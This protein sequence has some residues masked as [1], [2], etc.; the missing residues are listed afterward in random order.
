MQL[1]VSY[2]FKR[3]ALKNDF[4]IRQY[5]IE[6]GM[7]LLKDDEG[8]N[9]LETSLE[10]HQI[11]NVIRTS[12]HRS[13]IAPPHISVSE[14]RRN[15]TISSVS[16]VSAMI[17]NGCDGNNTNGNGTNGESNSNVNGF[18]HPSSRPLNVRPIQIKTEPID[19][20][21]EDTT[22][23]QQSKNVQ[24]SPSN[25]SVSLSIMTVNSS[26]NGNSKTP[27][28]IVINGKVTKSPEKTPSKSNKVTNSA[29][30]PT[31]RARLSPRKVNENL[32]PRNQFRDLRMI[33]KKAPNQ[34]E[35][36]KKLKEAALQVVNKREKNGR[37]ATKKVDNNNKKKP[38]EKRKIEVVHNKK[39]N[40]PQIK[41][42]RPPKPQNE[43]VRRGVRVGKGRPRK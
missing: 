9:D 36:K 20:D 19:P 32:K 3:L 21:Y 38:Q 41:R 31:L 23:G 25:S 2:N 17:M 28:M 4:Y 16:G 26:N 42:G 13:L 35:V 8:D 37:G 22:S 12:H 39:K 5:M 30:S 10:I 29:S 6:N 43:N 27:P 40:Q 11:H 18:V 7:N 24:S 1:N 34:A 15:S 14:L 33:I